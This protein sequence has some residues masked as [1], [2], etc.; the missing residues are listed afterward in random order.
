M[1]VGVGGRRRSKGEGE[2]G[3]QRGRGKEEGKGGGGRGRG[4][5]GKGGG[6]RRRGKEEGKGGGEKR[7]EKEQNN[8]K[9][10]ESWEEKEKPATVT[11]DLT[12]QHSFTN[13]IVHG[14][15]HSID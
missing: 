11:R 7:R 8:Q 3:G 4:K 9:Q 14:I 6:E 2:G 5:E 15:V 1:E 10:G 13:D 12:D